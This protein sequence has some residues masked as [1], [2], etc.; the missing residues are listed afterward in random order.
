MLRVLYTSRCSLIINNFILDNSFSDPACSQ[1]SANIQQRHFSFKKFRQR[2]SSC[3]TFPS[4]PTQLNPVA[5]HNQQSTARYESSCSQKLPAFPQAVVL[6]LLC[7]P[8]VKS[9]SLSHKESSK[10]VCTTD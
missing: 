1:T 4:T 9:K 8:G 5:A 2:V 6:R 3:D 7:K 10:H